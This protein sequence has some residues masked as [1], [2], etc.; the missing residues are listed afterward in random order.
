MVCTRKYRGGDL[1][2]MNATVASKKTMKNRV[3]NLGK[4]AANVR[5]RVGAKL[6]NLGY[7]AQNLYAST[8]QKAGAVDMTNLLSKAKT[9]KNKATAKAKNLGS[10]VTAKAMNLGKTLKNKYNMKMTSMKLNSEFLN[11]PNKA[12]MEPGAASRNLLKVANKQKKNRN[13]RTRRN[14]GWSAG[15][16]YQAASIGTS[17]FF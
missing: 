1:N 12:G 7:R 14:N 3:K 10:Q 2:G 6:M 5:N 16:K 15:D 13:N 8:F 17:L 11:R 4:K 9:L